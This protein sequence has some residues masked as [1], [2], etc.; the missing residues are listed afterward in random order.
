MLMAR[1]HLYGFRS[2]KSRSSSRELN[3]HQPTPESL[4]PVLW[5]WIVDLVS[6]Y[7]IEVALEVHV[8]WPNGRGAVVEARS[9]IENGEKDEG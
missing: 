9:E 8:N 2:E 1:L 5:G 7:L 4:D 6:R 3:T